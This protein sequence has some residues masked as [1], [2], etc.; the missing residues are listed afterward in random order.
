M[1]YMSPELLLF[2]TCTFL[3]TL[4]IQYMPI[5]GIQVV[6]RSYFHQTQSDMSSQGTLTARTDF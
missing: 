6:P 1:T 3:E 4:N 5:E 2:Y